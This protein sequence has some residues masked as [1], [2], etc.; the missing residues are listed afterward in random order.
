MYHFQKKRSCSDNFAIDAMDSRQILA[1]HIKTVECG[2]Y[3]NIVAFLLVHNSAHLWIHLFT[4]NNKQQH[5]LINIRIQSPK[6]VTHAA[7]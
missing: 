2:T 1:E 7:Y 4:K 6:T 5:T 3:T